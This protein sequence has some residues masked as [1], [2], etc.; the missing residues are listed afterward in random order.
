[1]DFTFF[2]QFSYLQIVL[3]LFIISLLIQLFYYLY[4]YSRTGFAKKTVK[5]AG[6]SPV[7]IIICARDEAHNLREF[8]PSILSQDY[9]DYEVIVV[10]DCSEDGTQDL[11]EEFQKKYK[12]LRIST[13]KKDAKFKHGKKFALLIGI[14]AAK[15]EWLLLTDADCY[16]ESDK[17]LSTMQKNFTEKTDIVIGY[18]GYQKGKGILN[19]FIRYE[20][21]FIA[22]QYFGFAMAGFPYMGVGRNLAYRKSFFFENKGFSSHY[23]LVSG[24]DD[25]FVNKLATRDNTKTEYSINSH[26]R[27]IPESTFNEWIKQKKRHLVTGM[28]YRRRDKILLGGEVIS[29]ILFYSSLIYLLASQTLI[30]W[31]LGGFVLR[32]IC[33]LI[34]FKYAMIKLEEKHLLLSSLIYDVASPLLNFGIFITNLSTQHRP[35]WK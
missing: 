9:P 11:L 7:S 13:I 32:L 4:F 15:H 19:N 21:T 24:D 10:N 3:G 18:G 28:F 20:T 2:H 26:I 22:M 30:L 17:W 12:N 1:M 35:S 14:K 5:K 23:H 29:R 16:A 6:P 27:S 31:I 25:L 33:Q 8:L 34:I